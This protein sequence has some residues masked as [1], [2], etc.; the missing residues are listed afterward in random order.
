[1]L[2]LTPVHKPSF[3]R[4][5]GASLIELM[6]AM[7][8][9]LAALSAIA[10]LVGFGIGVNGKLLSNS[11]LNE[12]INSIGALITRDLKRAGFSADTIN[13]VTNPVDFPSAFRNSISVS[14]HPDEDED[15]CMLYAYDQNAN[16]VLDTVG[17][18][19]NFGFRLRNGT[20]QIRTNGATCA[21]DSWQELTDP[22]IVNITELDFDIDLVTFNNVVSTQITVTIEGEL[23]VNDALSRQFNSRFL[24]R[25]Y[26]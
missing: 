7:A 20:V 15:S 25:N 4:Q 5:A 1:M 3:S 24:V 26:D 13:M 19:E 10:S 16:G 17:S 18:N 12:E 23:V 22:D 6:I 21:S 14:E 2:V 8:L 11:R 9:G